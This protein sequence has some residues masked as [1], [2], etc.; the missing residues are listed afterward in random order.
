MSPKFHAVQGAISSAALYP[1]I[2]TDALVFGLTVFLIDLDHI[3][4]FVRDCRSLDIR[5]FFE[6]HRVVPDLP[7]YLALAW[8]H[9]LEFFLL[10]FALGFW[11]H[12]FWVMLAAC[13]FHIIFDVVKA[14][15]MGKPHIRAFSFVEYAIRR[16][17]KMTRH[18]V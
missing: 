11:K 1:F 17:G 3:I 15:Q 12:Q 8:F 9:T 18:T 14:I 6:Y 7:D 13:L 16:K 4:P 10:L 2:G 5:K